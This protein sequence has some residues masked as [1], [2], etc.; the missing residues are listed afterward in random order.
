MKHKKIFISIPILIIL[1]TEKVQADK[2]SLGVYPPLIRIRSEPDVTVAAPITVIN[3]SDKKLNLSINLK[4]IQSASEKDGSVEYFP[5]HALS[6]KDSIFLRNVILKDDNNP[7]KSIELYPNESKKLILEFKSPNKASDYYFSVIFSSQVENE[8]S[9]TVLK[10]SSGVATNVL[11]S[12]GSYQS[13]GVITEF[14]TSRI[15]LKG[16]IRISLTVGNT[17]KSYTNA[18]G[19]ITI[20][21]LFGNK[22]GYIPLRNAILLKDATRRLSSGL[23]Q[24]DSSEIVWGEKFL[25]GFYTAKAVVS[26][27][28][29]YSTSATTS[30][31]AI[32]LFLLLALTVI[33][34][35][36]LSILFR[37]IRKLNFKES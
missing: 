17:G 25:F 34:F 29:V 30:F 5:P 7:I 24:T 35:I 28:K 4:A 36:I 3:T 14:S 16:P 20:Y 6:N 2:V 33:F 13:S 18:S 32:P 21:D 19:S 8:S 9:E 22:A 12:I 37:V 27:D 10:T 31:F 26:F 23:P 11:V 15:V 1:L